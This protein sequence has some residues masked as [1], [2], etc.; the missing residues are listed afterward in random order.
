MI[1]PKI[2]KKNFSKLIYSFPREEATFEVNPRWIDSLEN[3][4]EFINSRLNGKR[5]EGFLEHGV[6]YI[7]VL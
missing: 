2:N 5:V 4:V 3:I 7:R 6:R 1:N